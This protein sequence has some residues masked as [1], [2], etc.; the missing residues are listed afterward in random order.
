MSVSFFKNIANK[1]FVS[2]NEQNGL[3]VNT[4]EL[5]DLRKIVNR[6]KD[7]HAKQTSSLFAGN[8]KSAFKG[9]G[10]EFEEIRAYNFGDNVKDMDWRVTAR[11]NEP[12]IKVFQEEKDREIYVIL[13]FSS[14]MI[15]GTKRELKSVFAAK[16]AAVLGW[17]ALEN[18]DRFGCIIYDGKHCHTLKAKGGLKN[19]LSVFK[20][21]SKMSKDILDTQYANP[22]DNALKIAEKTIKN[23]SMV[24]VISD[25][26]NFDENMSKSISA[27]SKKGKIY[28]LQIA[29]LLEINAPKNGEYTAEY[30]DTKV[31]FD[32]YHKNFKNIYS[33]FFENKRNSL[34]NFALKVG[35]YY[36]ILS[37]GIE[38]EKQIKFI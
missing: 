17:F 24:F 19:L 21:I 9:R 4:E 28:I 3:F 6:I 2:K 7:K 29:D 23:Q 33:E 22:I 26:H 36:A 8:I 34:K 20:I 11:R 18:N 1:F 38:I 32:T 25:F 10:L 35:I 30:A 12:Y 14:S 16:I 13:D 37:N 31:S 5:T 15:F 27:L